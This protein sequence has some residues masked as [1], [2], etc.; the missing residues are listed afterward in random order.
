MT[1]SWR[2]GDFPIPDHELDAHYARM[3]PEVFACEDP[4]GEWIAEQERLDAEAFA[5]HLREDRDR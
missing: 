4:E 2:T 5:Y 3:E 1:A